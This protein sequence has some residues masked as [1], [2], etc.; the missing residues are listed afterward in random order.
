MLKVNSF[1]YVRLDTSPFDG[2]LLNHL[3]SCIHRF[4]TADTELRGD[5]KEAK[6][7]ESSKVHA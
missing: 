5:A 7:L 4:D 2:I 6:G 1:L 3:S